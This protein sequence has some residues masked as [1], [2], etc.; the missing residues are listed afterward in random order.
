MEML[1]QEYE[2]KAYRVKNDNVENNNNSS[3]SNRKKIEYNASHHIVS[4]Q[5]FCIAWLNKQHTMAIGVIERDRVT[6]KKNQFNN[7]HYNVRLHALHRSRFFSIQSVASRSRGKRTQ[8]E[9]F[10]CFLFLFFILQI[11]T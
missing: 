11:T 5:N 4:H 8:S 6:A 10:S 9:S 1:Q 3:G 2:T 7:H